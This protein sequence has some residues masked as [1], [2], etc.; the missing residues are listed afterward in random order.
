MKITFGNNLNNGSEPVKKTKFFVLAIILLFAFGMP[1][2]S[3]IMSFTNFGDKFGFTGDLVKLATQMAPE[4][5]G[6]E[7]IEMPS[8]PSAFNLIENFD[9]IVDFVGESPKLMS[10][11]ADFVTSDGLMNFTSDYGT[12][13]DIE[14]FIEAE[15]PENAGPIGTPNGSVD[16]KWYREVDILLDKPGTMVS[17]RSMGG[18]INKSY[19]YVNKGIEKQLGDVKGAKPSPGKEVDYPQCNFAD[20]WKL[21]IEKGANKDAVA[22]IKYDSSGYNFSI[23][24]TDINFWFD[25]TCKFVR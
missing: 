3:M 23:D 21:A 25:Q 4:L 19:Q 10:I 11:K 8:N 13:A 1:I 17:V 18:G 24:N 5:N 15:K 16:G 2:V 7:T 6:P 14:F 12:R 20:L 22:R 9:K